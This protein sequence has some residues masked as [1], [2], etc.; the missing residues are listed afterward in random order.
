M[1][2]KIIKENKIKFHVKA[3]ESDTDLTKNRVYLVDSYLYMDDDHW[4]KIKNDSGVYEYYSMR[5]FKIL[6]EIDTRREKIK[7]ILIKIKKPLI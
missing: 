4:Y 7:N 2:W 6:N 5:F 3:I 1:N